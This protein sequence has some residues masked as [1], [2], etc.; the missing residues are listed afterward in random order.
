MQGVFSVKKTPLHIAEESRKCLDLFR[1]S[2]LFQTA[3]VNGV[4]FEKYVDDRTLLEYLIL[5]EVVCSYFCVLAG[6]YRYLR[7]KEELPLRLEDTQT[8]RGALP[9]IGR[10]SCRERV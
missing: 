5:N 2:Q 7:W 6:K 8:R 4:I 3:K 1:I 10:A 9:Q